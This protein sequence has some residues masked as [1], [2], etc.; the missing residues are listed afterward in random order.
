MTGILAYS[1]FVAIQLCLSTAFRNESFKPANEG[2]NTVSWLIRQ[3]L[4]AEV[5]QSD[6]T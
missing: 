5:E 4:K 1:G 2:G 3:H 6:A